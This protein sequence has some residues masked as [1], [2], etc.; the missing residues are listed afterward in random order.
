M[1]R[2]TALIAC[3]ASAAAFAP[4]AVSARCI[5]GGWRVLRAC[6]CHTMPC[7]SIAHAALL[8][9]R[10]RGSLCA[11]TV[12]EWVY[13]VQAHAAEGYFLLQPG[14]SPG[15]CPPRGKLVLPTQLL[16]GVPARGTVDHSRACFE[17]EMPCWTAARRCA[18]TGEGSEATVDA[19]RL[20]Q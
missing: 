17:N 9:T 10:S 1:L 7:R 13:V 11:L 8:R 3:V 12:G 4:G 18:L 14:P 6:C 2:I 19:G 15:G 20:L 16:L 5:A